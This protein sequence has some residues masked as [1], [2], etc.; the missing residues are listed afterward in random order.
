MCSLTGF[1]FHANV[2]AEPQLYVIQHNNILYTKWLSRFF[3][4]KSI[5]S[6]VVRLQ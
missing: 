6:L 2:Y 1:L 3:R 4:L 5:A